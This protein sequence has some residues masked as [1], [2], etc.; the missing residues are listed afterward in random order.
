MEYVD[1]QHQ[2]E[3]LKKLF[4]EYGLPVLGGIIVALIILLG[5]QYYQSHKEQVA[6][7]ASSQYMKVLNAK[8]EGQDETAKK[9]AHAIMK[10]YPGTQYAVLSAMLL[11]QYQA[12]AQHY[13]QAQAKLKWAINNTDLPSL[14]AL[15][16]I[17][18]ARLAFQ[19]GEHNKALKE[20]KQVN[21]EAFNGLKQEIKGDIA[22][23]DKHYP[24]AYKAYQKAQEQLP[25][26]AH[27]RL[28][29]MKIANLPITA[30]K[31]DI[32]PS[33]KG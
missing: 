7:Q 33:Q 20:L 16:H 18:K 4:K 19:Q 28:I 27:Q 3:H 29:A 13:S 10:T 21:S 6:E 30:S 14:R 31:E 17:R 25:K 23:S 11:A 8:G 2:V 24:K 32:K 15:G 1:E 12:K 22:A 5:W 9:Q 26:Q